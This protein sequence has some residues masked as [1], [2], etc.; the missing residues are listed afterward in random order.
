MSPDNYDSPPSP[1]RSLEDQ[2]HM[3]YA[4]EDI[5]G[6]KILLLRLQGIEVTS[7]DDP[8]I[9][10]I[11]DDD[12][13]RFFMPNGGL[14][15][16]E[17][18]M[19]ERQAREMAQI[20]ARR[21]MERLRNCE[22]KWEQEK[23][24]M[25]DE[26]LTVLRRREKKRQEEDERRRRAEENERRRLA[27][28]EQ[29]RTAEEERRRMQRERSERA[30]QRNTRKIVSYNHLHPSRSPARRSQF[31]YDFPC[32]TPPRQPVPQQQPPPLF[33]DSTA[34]PFTDVLISMHG[35]LFPLTADESR[36]KDTRLLDALLVHIEQTGDE[37]RRRKGKYRSQLEFGPCRACSSFS[38]SSIPRTSSWLSFRST[39]SSASSSM[40]DLSTPSTS[41]PM[42]LPKSG[43]FASPPKSSIADPII[44]S[45]APLR[46]SCHQRTRLVHVA[47][48]DSPLNLDTPQPASRSARISHRGSQRSTSTVRAAKE[49]AG[50]LVRRISI[51]VE[52]AKGFQTTYAGTALFGLS[53]SH[54]NFDALAFC[55]PAG[56]DTNKG[57]RG[58]WERV[59]P[60]RA[61]RLR[62]AGY[63]A[64]VSD[65]TCFLASTSPVG[66][67]LSDQSSSEANPPPKY[68]PLTSPYPPTD[69]PHT[70]L[71]S[72][73]PYRLIF[74]P[75]PPTSHSPF[76]FHAMSEL[77]TMYPSSNPF[78][79]AVASGQVTWRLRSVGNPVHMRLKAL[80]NM[81]KRYGMHWEGAA[82]ETALG[83][84]RERVVGVAYEGVGR[85]MLKRTASSPY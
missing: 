52:L 61:P 29:R 47:L 9:D 35:P 70:V 24:R 20:Q 69:I 64:S 72:P 7:D 82:R 79:P 75:I 49:G 40:T 68:I 67:G 5:H 50:A 45:P 53:A 1:P 83:G 6:A 78:P 31:V 25:R 46:H 55:D 73:L 26:R 23:Q 41:P 36:R 63:R 37:R 28:E 44:S 33:D 71:P 3:A 13:D 12:F 22:K 16:D 32:R 34:V 2:V 77:H 15:M 43:W 19:M 42:S 62:P 57:V 18:A 76:R 81:V 30:A 84:G 54:D 48:V 51:F 10:A 27:E 39:S 80:H 14:M 17:K 66:S 21:R 59:L 8:R 74:K 56:E 38:P 85:S 58:T 4:L 11:Q 65:V 60:S